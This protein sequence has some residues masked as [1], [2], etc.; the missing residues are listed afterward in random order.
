M[1]PRRSRSENVPKDEATTDRRAL[2]LKLAYAAI[3]LGL[4]ARALMPFAADLYQDGA[5]YVAMGDSWAQN[6]ELIMPHGDVGHSNTTPVHSQQYPPAYPTYYGLFF[7]VFGAGLAQAKAAAL[8]VSLAAV[9]AVYLATR[10][11]H[12]RFVAALATGLVALEPHL[13]WV[14]GTGFSENLT[15]LF[16]TAMAWAVVKSLK[17]DRYVLLVALFGALVYLT[18]ISRAGVGYFVVFAGLGALAWGLYHKRKA[19][20]RSPWYMGAIAVF[21][22]V[23]GLWAWRNVQLF[24]GGDWASSDYLDLRQ[25]LRL[26]DPIG[27]YKAILGKV[28][29]F[30]AFFAFY[31]FAFLPDLRRSWSRLREDREAAVLWLV[32]AVVWLLA[33]VM[34]GLYWFSDQGP[35]WWLDNH[36][37]VIVALVPLAW[38]ALREL[39]PDR[40]GLLKYGAAASV[41]LLLT[42]LVVVNPVR[43][44]EARAAEWMDPYLVPEDNIYLG[45]VSKYSLYPYVQDPEEVNFTIFR[46]TA[47]GIRIT[48]PTPTWFVTNN[49]DLGQIGGYTRVATF[50]QHYLLDS[51]YFGESSKEVVT[52]VWVRSDL[53]DARGI[54]T[55][56][57]EEAW[58]GLVR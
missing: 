16:F 42:A 6:G 56:V 44:P 46:L 49:A 28:P 19:F 52:R 21:L 14:T 57:T 35:V 43:Y 11:L 20:F 29:L 23:F 54:P 37:Y 12:G 22:L 4:L 32:V 39:R 33:L 27:A 2:L 17:D 3:A 45:K 7:K 51:V 50:R 48:G 15:L 18:R 5:T 55:N 1:A 40:A 9:G 26:S 58:P 25:T 13:V 38:L 41:F 8:V 36:R 31:A 24:T 47:Q 34:S 53:V 10:D 30:L